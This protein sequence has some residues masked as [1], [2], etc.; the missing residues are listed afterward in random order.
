M[1]NLRYDAHCH[2]FTLEYAV[3]E[4]KNMFRD[5]CGGTYPFKKPTKALMATRPL[6]VST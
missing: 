6:F 5:M 1:S 3:K 2:I 4:A